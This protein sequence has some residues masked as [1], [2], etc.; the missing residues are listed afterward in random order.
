MCEYKGQKHNIEFEITQQDVPAILGGATCL[1]LGLVKRM[2]DVCKENDIFGDYAMLFNAPGCLPG[3]H[4][5]QVDHTVPPIVHALRR[6]PVALR[7]R[8]VEELQRREKL[9]VIAKQSEPTEWVNSMVTVV[10]PRKIHICMDP[11]D[12]HKAIK[13]VHYPLLTIEKVVSRMPNAKFFSPEVFQRA[14]AQMIEGFD[15]VVNIID[16]L[17]VWSDSMEEHDH[18]LKKLLERARGYNLKLNRHQCLTAD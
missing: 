13:R 14:V 6:I 9:G 1:K 5:I 11:K 17:L 2:R 3:K 4:H 18:R 12:L 15:G 10:T 16:D 8:V 7:D